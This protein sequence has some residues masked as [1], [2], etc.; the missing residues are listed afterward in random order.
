MITGYSSLGIAGFHHRLYEPDQPAD[1][2]WLD[3]A[4]LRDR[5]NITLT[6]VGHLPM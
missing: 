4:T 1:V 2:D 6:W 5:Q 3:R